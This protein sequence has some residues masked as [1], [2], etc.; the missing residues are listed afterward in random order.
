MNSTTVLSHSEGYLC[1]VSTTVLLMSMAVVI[2][3]RYEQPVLG[4]STRMLNPLFIE[5]ARA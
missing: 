3:K 5:H 4:E 1:C 2:A